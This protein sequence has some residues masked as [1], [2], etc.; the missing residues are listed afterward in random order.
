MTPTRT[1]AVATVAAMLVALVGLPTRSAAQDTTKAQGVRIGLTYTQGTKPGVLITPIV[2][3]NSDS[4]REILARDLDFGDRVNPIKL[5]GGTPPT[6]ALNYPLY[7]QQGALA[8]V[9]AT[10]TAVGSLHVAVHDVVA[11]RVMNVFDVALPNP[12]LGPE[13]R[14]ALHGASDEVERVITE[15]RGIAQTR[16][17]FERAGA[18][19]TV[20]SDGA[21][22][23]VLPGTQ[24]GLSPAW[25]PSGRYM[26]FCLLANDGQFIMLRDLVAGT[27]R[28]IPGHGASS[29]TPAFSPDGTTLVFSSGSDGFDIFTVSPFGKEAPQRLTVGRGSVINQQPSFSPDG[30]RVAFQS[31]RSGHAEVYIM[32]ADGS[33]A[34]LLTT[35]IGGEQPYRSN[36]DWSPDG[37][38]V[39]FQSQINGV[40]QIMTINPRDRSVTALTSEGRNEDPSWAPDGRHLAFT[41]NRSGS[42]QL[43]VLDAESGRVRQL[44]R[45]E[46]ARM[47][48]WS[49]RLEAAR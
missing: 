45:G 29:N 44:T 8:V 13:W 11:A 14:M 23:H 2:G 20:D 21:N 19:W 27:S 36:P 42:Q 25:H 9:Q 15:Q 49:P 6:G 12:P 31:D 10:L 35:S 18:L 39:A 32:D 16:V 26:A 28:R 38:K 34:D 5:D 43:W 46:K 17:A 4:V 3:A 33:N 40:F 24:A 37:R 7:A 48:A 41:S 47:A 22:A 1:L 30:R